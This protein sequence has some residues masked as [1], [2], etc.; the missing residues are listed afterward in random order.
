MMFARP[1]ISEER[2]LVLA[3]RYAA[4]H[5]AVAQSGNGGGWKTGTWLARCLGF[6]LGIVG[7][8]MFAGVLSQAPAP[9]LVGGV[10]L[11]V[12]AEWMVAQRRVLRSGVEEALYLCGAIAIVVQVLIWNSR[13]GNEWIGAALISTAVL[14][15][16]WRLLNPLLTTLAAIGFSLAIAFVDGRLIGVN[17]NTLWAGVACALLAIAALAAGSR[18]YQRP[19]HDRMLDGF[20][21]VMPWLGYGWLV[22]YSGSGT[23]ITH[24]IALAVALGFL[25]ANITVGVIRRQ[26][27]PLIGALGNMVCAAYSL[28]RLLPWPTH[29]QMVA[30]G[31]VLLAAAIVLDRQLH[32][33]TQGITSA[34]IE[35]PA[36]LD[37]VQVVGTA[38]LAPA[39]STPPPVGV[40]G[41]GG[42]FGGGG[43]SG[44]F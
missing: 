5:G 24:G 13:G 20:V 1:T 7:T 39:P 29:W 22:E 43:A 12:A 38:H 36:G 15:A 37:L 6:V 17:M 2:W 23:A 10:M 3:D 33:R 40:Q 32:R 19:F 35:E 8:A 14:L 44:R 16:G 18:E 21:I 34:A 11:V 31:A 26:H 28:H 27:A 30:G 42:E 4:L 41:Q 25:A 9:W